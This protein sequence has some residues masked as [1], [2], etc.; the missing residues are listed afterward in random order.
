MRVFNDTAEYQSFI[1]GG[2]YITPNMCLISESK[3][4]YCKPKVSPWTYELH[5]EMTFDEMVE[6]GGI[7]YGDFTELLNLTINMVETLYD[8]QYGDGC[9]SLENIPSK[10]NVTFAGYKVVEVNY[11]GN[12]YVSL[13]FNDGGTGEIVVFPDYISI[14][15]Y[16]GM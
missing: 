7:L 1:E 8:R 12:N 10:Y 5:I 16:P 2:E 3:D 14:D 13:T 4:L 6:N 15:S 11:D 9:F